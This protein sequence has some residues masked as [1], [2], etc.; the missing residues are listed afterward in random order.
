MAPWV[1]DPHSGGTKIPETLKEPTKRRILAHAEKRYAGRYTRLDVRFKGQHCY[2]DA[3]KEP[4]TRGGVWKV[5]GEKREQYIERMRNT[6]THLCRLR[7]LGKDRWSVAFYAYSH[8][9]YEPACFESGEMIGT[10][11]EGLDVGAVYLD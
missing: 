1:F 10:P 11:E 7:H 3:F 6:P 8:E 9:R 4:E 5:T 2:I